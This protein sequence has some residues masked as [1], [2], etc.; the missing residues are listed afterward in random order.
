MKIIKLLY[1]KY[2]LSFSICLISSFVIFFIF[3][4]I[5]NLNEDYLFNIILSISLLNSLQ[6]LVY[7][8][9]FIFLLSVI[10]LSNFLR[11]KNEIVIIK[12][13]INYKKLLIFFLPI[14]LVFT[15]LEINKKDLSRFLDEINN[16][17]I[18]ENEKPLAKIIINNQYNSK[19][20]TVLND[21]DLNNLERT[22]YRFYRVLDQIIDRAEFSND[23]IKS[24]DGL[25]ANSYTTYENDII[26]NINNKKSIEIDLFN[27]TNN[28]VVQDISKKNN[29]FKTGSVYLYIFSILLLFYIFLFFF[30]KKYVNIKQSLYFPLFVSL[31]FLM[32]SFLV[33]N[34]NLVI[35]KNFFELL[36]CVLIGMLIFKISLNE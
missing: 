15:I 17:L 18:N 30:N 21:I 6:I 4:L 16:N 10:L 33:F 19:N 5:S 23:L 11:S 7:V 2:F 32:Y 31:L 13:Y 28:K 26:R 24:K 12:S 1:T 25:I 9:I 35:Y 3:S 29:V 34:N 27:M 22:E 20:F 8:P 36:S 14:I